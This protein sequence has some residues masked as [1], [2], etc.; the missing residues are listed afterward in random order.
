MF[1]KIALTALSLLA[2]VTAQQVGNNTA[3]THPK[4]PWQKCTTSGGCVTQSNGAVVLDSNWRW[5]HTTTGYTNCYTGNEWDASLCPD[6][7]TCAENCALEGADYPGTY[8]VTTSGNALTLKYVTTS[9]EKNVGSRLYLLNS[10]TEYEMFMLMNQ[11][12]TFDVDVS[13]LPCGLNGAL[14]FTEMDADGGMA[15]HPTNK[16]GAKYGTGYCD[17]QCPRDLKFINGIANSEGWTASPNDENSG[18]GN[19]G[20][21]CNEMDIWESNSIASAYTAHPCTPDGLALCEGTACGTDDRYA[22]VCDPDG[23]DFNSFRMGDKTFLGPSMTVDTT[24]K[25]TVVTQFIA[26]NNSTSGDLVEIRRLYVQD[27]VVIQNSKVNVPGMTAGDSIT[28]DFCDEQKSV[29]GDPTQF[30]AKGGLARMGT[31]IKNGMVLVLSIW[32]DHTANMLWLDSD[33]PA[34]VDPSTPGVARGSC[35]IT[36]GVP[37]EVESQHPDASVTYSNIRVGDI[38]STF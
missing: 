33:Y 11:E 8:G 23:C 20:A 30:Q 34:D 24:K 16:A 19:L 2:V 18:T 4:L 10:E 38:G 37:S 12:F 31:A 9:S 35:P 32:D 27:G 14:Y 5:T 6:G 29:F 7:E 1:P 36:S 22:T 13:E 3:E 26:S 21:C 28:E 15:K 17:A 25:F